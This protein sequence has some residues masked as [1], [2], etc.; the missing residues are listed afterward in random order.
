M[1]CILLRM[2]HNLSLELDKNIDLEDG[3]VYPK[4]KMLLL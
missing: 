4:Q 3:G 2:E 1:H